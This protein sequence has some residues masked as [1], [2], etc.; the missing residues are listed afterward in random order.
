M[1]PA[2]ALGA[3]S[4]NK[5]ILIHGQMPMSSEDLP[6]RFNGLV[7]EI[8]KVS[9]VSELLSAGGSSCLSLSPALHPH[10]HLLLQDLVFPDLCHS[11]QTL[12]SRTSHHQTTPRIL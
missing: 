2:L 11:A 8:D 3:F 4:W 1:G 9:L 5:Q 12:S 7:S 10:P 6:Y